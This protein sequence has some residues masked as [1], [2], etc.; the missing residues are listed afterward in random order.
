MSSKKFVLPFLAPISFI[1]GLVHGVPIW[2]FVIEASRLL[3]RTF[4]I[5]FPTVV[6]LCLMSVVISAF[7][8]SVGR[9]AG[10]KIDD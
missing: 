4:F 7:E 10:I 9:A 3:F 1:D 5:D 2:C 8:V 6:L